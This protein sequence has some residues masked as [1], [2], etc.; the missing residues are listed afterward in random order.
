M[1]RPALAVA[2][3]AALCA[4]A[5]VP[6]VDDGGCPDEPTVG[7]AGPTDRHGPPPGR[8]AMVV[9]A[10]ALAPAPRVATITPWIDPAAPAPILPH[11]RLALAPKTSPPA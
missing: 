8:P 2:L 9:P 5:L 6:P 1:V 3:C 7:C 10:V 11:D 4:A